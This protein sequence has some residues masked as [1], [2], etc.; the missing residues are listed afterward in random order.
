LHSPLIH[1]SDTHTYPTRHATR[2]LFTVPKS[3]NNFK[4]AYTVLYRAVIAWNSLPSHIAQINSKSGLKKT[5]KVTPHGKTPLL[6]LAK[7]V[8]VFIDM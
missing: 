3:R 4:K 8:C 2:G 7:V 5:D 1:S 6:Y